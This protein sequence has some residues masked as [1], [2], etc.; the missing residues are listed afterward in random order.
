[1]SNAGGRRERKKRETMDRIAN[2]AAELFSSR[3]YDA[4]T[5]EDIG[6]CADVSRATV[7]NHFARKEDLVLAWFDTRRVGLADLLTEYTDRP[8]DATSRLRQAFRALAR[9]FEEDPGTGRGMMRAWLLAGGPLLTPGSPTERLFADVIQ[10]GQRQGNIAQDVDADTAGRL[11]FD[12]YA[13]VLYR[14]VAADKPISL[15][16]HLA[17]TLELI[18][19]GIAT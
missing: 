1:M 14:W 3:G 6:E 9:I 13:G 17:S 5:M 15:E 19:G 2:C 18:L 4:T 11:L 7:F 8:D 12:A 16:H 10:A